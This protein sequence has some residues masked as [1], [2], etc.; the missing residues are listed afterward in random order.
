MISFD[1]G[2]NRHHWLQMQ[3]R[4]VALVCFGNQITAMTQARMHACGLHQ[5]AVDKSGIQTRFRVD[6][7]DHC[8]GRGFTV[9]PGNSNTVTKTH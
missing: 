7:G 2:D 4:R 8:R 6:A 5:T 3:E 9:R 1:I